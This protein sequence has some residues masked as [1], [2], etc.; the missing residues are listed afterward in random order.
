MVINSNN[1][2]VVSTTLKEMDATF[3]DTKESVTIQRTGSTGI[4]MQRTSMNNTDMGNIL[5]FKQDHPTAN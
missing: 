5:Y 1:T 4:T 2:S 3:T